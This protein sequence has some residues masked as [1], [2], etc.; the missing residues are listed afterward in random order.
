MGSL[1][2]LRHLVKVLVT[3]KIMP[4]S[5]K[6]WKQAFLTP[7]SFNWNFIRLFLTIFSKNI[8]A[9]Y[10]YYQL[11]TCYIYKKIKYD[12]VNYMNFTIKKKIWVSFKNSKSYIFKNY[13]DIDLI[14]YVCV[15]STWINIYTIFCQILKRL[16]RDFTFC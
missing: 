3:L 10:L 14:F 12:Q 16:S 7:C 15:F 9:I 2:I 13:R 11:L 8:S 4:F 6:S 5:K 1:V